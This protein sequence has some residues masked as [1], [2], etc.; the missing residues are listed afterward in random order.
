MPSELVPV[1]LDQSAHGEDGRAVAHDQEV[2]L[3]LELRDVDAH[4]ALGLDDAV[5]R[6]Q[7]DT[8]L[9]LAQVRQDGCRKELSSGEVIPRPRVKNP[10]R[11]RLLGAGGGGAG[12]RGGRRLSLSLLWLLP[13]A[14]L[15]R[16]SR[17]TTLGLRARVG[18]RL[19]RHRWA[20]MQERT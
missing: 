9:V 4:G 14:S 10:S 19:S 8:V 20:F 11:G 6:G 17:R 5:G 18:D 12:Q 13:L 16:T 2:S 3:R 1:V 7:L 15:G